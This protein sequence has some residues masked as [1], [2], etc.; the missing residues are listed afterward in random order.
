MSMAVSFFR[1]FR[2]EKNHRMTVTPWELA[3]AQR[4][5]GSVGPSLDDQWSLCASSVDELLLDAFAG[6]CAFGRGMIGRSFVGRANMIAS[7][8]SV[9]CGLPS[10]WGRGL[11]QQILCDSGR[12][13]TPPEIV[14]PN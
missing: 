14:G 4:R 9:G 8:E 1:C 7:G 11:P 12:L 3:E 5:H 13:D 2:R 10:S 6:R